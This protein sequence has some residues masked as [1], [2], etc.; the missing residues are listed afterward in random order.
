M[1][2]DAKT[3]SDALAL[4]QRTYQQNQGRSNQLSNLQIGGNE[5]PRTGGT[6]AF[7]RRKLQVNPVTANALSGILGGQAPSAKKT[8]VLNV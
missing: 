7:K 6:Q 1:A 5:A 8:N 4:G 3:R 2:L